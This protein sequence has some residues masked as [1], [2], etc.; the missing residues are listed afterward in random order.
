MRRLRQARAAGNVDH[1]AV[2]ESASIE[3]RGSMLYG[4]L[5]VIFVF[6]PVMFAGGVP[7]VLYMMAARGRPDAFLTDSQV[8]VYLETSGMA[9][10]MMMLTMMCATAHHAAGLLEASFVQPDL[11]VRWMYQ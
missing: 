2:I 7:F 1:L 6:L 3:I 11:M 10:M 8:R 9:M 4:T 5:A